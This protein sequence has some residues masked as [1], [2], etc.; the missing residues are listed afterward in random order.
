M[1][2]H[3]KISNITFNDNLAKS[4]AMLSITSNQNLYISE[5][6]CIKNKA[7]KNGYISLMNKIY[8]NCYRIMCF[9]FE[10]IY[11]YWHSHSLRKSI[12]G[13]FLLKHYLSN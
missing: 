12:T 2:N 11:L 8:L 4:A 1:N 13:Y 5:I 7:E 6:I 9:F 10:H 3:T